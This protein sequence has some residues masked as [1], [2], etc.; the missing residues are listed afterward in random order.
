MG[1]VDFLRRKTVLEQIWEGRQRK[2]YMKRVM[3]AVVSAAAI[4][5]V[6]LLLMYQW[7]LKEIGKMEFGKVDSE[8]QEPEREKRKYGNPKSSVGKKPGKNIRQWYKNMK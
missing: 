3:A 4:L 1:Y 2:I 6:S 5:S 8:L 7:T